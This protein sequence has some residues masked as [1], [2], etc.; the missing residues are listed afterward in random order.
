[1][2]LSVLP[3]LIGWGTVSRAHTA[4][5]GPGRGMTQNTQHEV[6]MSWDRVHPSRKA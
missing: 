5:T 1:M 6:S 2:R 3:V 4:E